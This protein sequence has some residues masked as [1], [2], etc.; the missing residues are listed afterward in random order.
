M[1]I[2]PLEERYD[3]RSATDRGCLQAG[4]SSAGREERFRLHRGGIHNPYRVPHPPPQR[5]TSYA[6]RD[7]TLEYVHSL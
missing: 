2:V 4:D 7:S 6:L 1:M 3:S 5:A